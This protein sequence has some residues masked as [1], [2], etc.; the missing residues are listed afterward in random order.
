[1]QARTWARVASHWAGS[2]PSTVPSASAQ[3]LAEFPYS[4]FT[5]KHETAL[6]CSATPRAELGLS[7]S[8][9]DHALRLM[10]AAQRAGS[11]AFTRLLLRLTT[12]RRAEEPAAEMASYEN[13][14]QR[15][16][17]GGAE[18]DRRSTRR[19]EEPRRL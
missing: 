16:K 9:Y 10:A 14:S 3:R 11:A 12:A 6:S 7:R 2:Q 1:M 5:S 8:L 18:T 19:A 15:P 17:S 4:L 13:G